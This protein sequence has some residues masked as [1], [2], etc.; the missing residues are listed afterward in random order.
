MRHVLLSLFFG[1]NLLQTPALADPPAQV[2]KVLPASVT[3][4]LAPTFLANALG[5][6]GLNGQI[7]T[8]PP[9]LFEKVKTALTQAGWEE[10]PIR[11][12]IGAWGFS[13]TWAL[14]SGVSVDGVSS[15]QQAVLVTQATAL[16]PERSNLNIRLEGL[17]R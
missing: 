16:G 17:S 14:P 3:A 11:A 12:T 9:Q 7:Q 4:K 10:Q 5:Q 2:L 15:G 8:T 1:V 6:T 13:A